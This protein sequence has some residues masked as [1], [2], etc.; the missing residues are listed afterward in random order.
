MKTSMVVLAFAAFTAFGFA[1]AADAPANGA[2]P[3][4]VQVQKSDAQAPAATQKTRA[5]V[6]QELL[7]AQQSG[8]L[9][10]LTQLYRGS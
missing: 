2:Q 9:S 6:R 8:Q 3:G 5:Q 1:H 4:S 10:Y 7:Q